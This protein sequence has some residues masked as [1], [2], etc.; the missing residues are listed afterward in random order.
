MKAVAVLANPTRAVELLAAFAALR[1]R[2]VDVPLDLD[3]PAPGPPSGSASEPAS[4]S[5]SEPAS[6][7]ASEPVQESPAEPDPLARMDGF[8]RRVGFTPTRLPAWLTA[9]PPAH[10]ESTRHVPPFSF[11]WAELLPSLT[12][13]LHLTDEDLRKTR[14]GWGGA[15]GG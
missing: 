11:D 15:V 5:A 1:A 6:G 9:R 7:P 2:T 8:A 10:T 12:L 14:S 3:P 13:Y 4:G